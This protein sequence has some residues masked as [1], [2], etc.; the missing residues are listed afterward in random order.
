MKKFLFLGAISLVMF[1]Q[2]ASADENGSGFFI[3]FDTGYSVT[4]M[5][6]AQTQQ[7][8]KSVV[9]PSLINIGVKA[10]YSYYFLSFLG[11]RGYLDYQYG[12][13]VSSTT[14]TG[15]QTQT[16]TTRNSLHQVAFNIDALINFVNTESFALGVYAGIGL[17]YANASSTNVEQNQTINTK[18]SDGFILPINVGLGITAGEHH[19]L[20]FGVKIPTL[21]TKAPLPAGQTQSN[22]TTTYKDLIVTIGYA[23]QF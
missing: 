5:E 1:S 22:T 17:G 18:R 14:Q 2:Y 15:Q 13:S 16:D 3:G 12:F 10:G 19:R 4:F 23:F 7:T 21:S 11:V 20:D 6:R 9:A 8:T